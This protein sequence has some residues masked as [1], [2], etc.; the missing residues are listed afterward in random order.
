MCAFRELSARDLS[1]LLFLDTRAQVPA[2]VVETLP[3]FEDPSGAEDG[4]QRR[5]RLVGH[6]RPAALLHELRKKPE[7]NKNMEKALCST[8]S[9]A[10]GHVGTGLL[11]PCPLPEQ[12]RSTS[13]SSPRSIRRIGFVQL[14]G[15]LCTQVQADHIGSSWKAPSRSS[16]EFTDSGRVLCAAS[17]SVH[18]RGGYSMTRVYPYSQ[19]GPNVGEGNSRM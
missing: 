9:A 6:C 19:A 10:G 1:W 8:S 4:S 5:S 12:P 18:V 11:L 7:S 3:L 16:T 15:V 13:E 14:P 17:L 2:S